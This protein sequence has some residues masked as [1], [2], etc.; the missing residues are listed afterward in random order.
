MQ[1][2]RLAKAFEP[3][4]PGNGRVTGNSLVLRGKKYGSGLKSFDLNETMH[5]IDYA[6]LT[7][8]EL[9]IEYTEEASL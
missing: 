7:A 5:I 2:P 3:I 1:R 4:I 6:I 8:Q 9:T